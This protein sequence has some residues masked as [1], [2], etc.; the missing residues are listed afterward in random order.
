MDC[1]FSVSFDKRVNGRQTLAQISA[2]TV[3]THVICSSAHGYQVNLLISASYE[4]QK[5]FM[6]VT[7]QMLANA[8][9]SS[10]SF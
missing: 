3:I 1:T 7:M 5:V 2:F 4:I 6:T 10:S 9:S 8:A